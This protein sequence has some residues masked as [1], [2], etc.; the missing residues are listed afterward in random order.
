MWRAARACDRCVRERS[1]SIRCPAVALP[2]FEHELV[3]RHRALRTVC[4]ILY[5]DGERLRVVLRDEDDMS[6]SDRG[7]SLELLPQRL[8][9]EWILGGC[10]D[11]PKLRCDL[12]RLD[13]QFRR[14]RRDPV[15]DPFIV[16]LHETTRAQ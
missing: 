3:Q 7:R 14:D 5:L 8:R 2:D 16:A 10:A 15:V 12:D 4:E 11:T 1:R 13:L 9:S 6:G